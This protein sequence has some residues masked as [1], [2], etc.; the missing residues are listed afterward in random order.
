MTAAFSGTSI[1]KLA[2][3]GNVWFDIVSFYIAEMSVSGFLTHQVR[4]VIWVLLPTL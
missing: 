4:N 1:H 3:S 2:T